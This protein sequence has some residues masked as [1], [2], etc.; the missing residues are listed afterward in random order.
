MT[1]GGVL[2]YAEAVRARYRAAM[3]V[4][5]GAILDE[6]CRTTGYHRKAA[7][8]LLAGSRR[9][10]RPRPRARRYGAEVAAA[11]AQVHAAAG[12][13]CAKRLV[14]FLPELVARLERHGELALDPQTRLLLLELS[15]ATADR[16]LGRGRRRPVQ[17]H[18]TAAAVWRGSVPLRTFGEWTDTTP[19]ALQA[20]LV[21]H[22]GGSTA[23]FYLTT[24]VVVDVATGWTELEALWGHGQERVAG[25]L[26]RIRRRLPFALRALHTDNGAEF[27]NATVL[28]WAGEHDV[29][30]SRGR[31]YRKNDQAWVEQ[32]NWTAVRRVVGYDR[33][34]SREAH[35]A[36]RA[37]YPALSAWL[38]L[39]QPLQKLTSKERHGAKLVRRYDLA[40]TPYRRLLLSGLAD[41][42]A[43]RALARY[44]DA[45]NPVALRREVECA[46][47][48]VWSTAESG[49]IR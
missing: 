5:K 2:E 30:L 33:Y 19:G 25:A 38:N 43:Q 41:E 44:F 17:E 7:I 28:R 9:P 46:V 11:L 34:S 20:D 27:L 12:G 49:R 35:A 3:K 13:I 48:R 47:E 24:L 45:V 6:F 31:P 22:G 42:G 15:A 1:R 10:P 18:R 14:P 26:E 8:R 40:R 37:L 21:V 16:L 4:E 29:T 32:R 23:G 36:L 39:L